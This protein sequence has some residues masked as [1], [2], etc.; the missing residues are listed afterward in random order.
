MKTLIKILP[1]ILL[2]HCST[3]DENFIKSQDGVD[4]YFER[5][6]RGVPT[7]IFIHGWSPNSKAW[8][9]QVDFFSKKYSVINLD[10]PGFGK[11]GHN[12]S[13]WTIENYGADIK[14]IIERLNLKRVI[15]V[16]HSMGGLVALSGANKIPDKIE[17]IVLV[18]ILNDINYHYSEPQIQEIITS[19]KGKIKKGNLKELSSFF[20]KPE[21]TE[22]YSDL[23]PSDIPDYWWDVLT[24]SFHWINNESKATLKGTRAP[25][26]SINSDRTK[27]D[28]E[29]FRQYCPNYN[30]EII[31]GTTHYLNWDKP[32]EF[33][34]TLLKC[35]ES[36]DR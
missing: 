26:L 33:N 4:I 12:R 24:D 25:V 7:I 5:S 15:L 8:K 34:D 23:L 19:W 22:R 1:I 21:L 16:G 20:S 29:A 13:E 9:E 11:S 3:N 35:I 31:S 10:L 14:T 30:A 36:M 28:I 17:G 2:T 27:T 6:G 18:D 32:N